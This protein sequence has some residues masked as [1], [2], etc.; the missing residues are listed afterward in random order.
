MRR[1]NIFK[2]LV[3]LLCI[4]GALFLVWVVVSFIDV[5]LNNSYMDSQ[6]AAWNFFRLLIS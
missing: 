3:N 6:I 2:L 4:I 5:N 1:K